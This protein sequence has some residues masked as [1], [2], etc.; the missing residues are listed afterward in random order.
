M[1]GKELAYVALIVKD[2]E[3]AAAAWEKDFGLVRSEHGVEGGKRK[4]PLMSVGQSA[5]ALFASG[6]PYVGG[7]ERT[8]VH[9]IALAVDHAASAA[10]AVGRAGVPTETSDT[11]A[12][13]DGGHRVLLSLKATDGLR[14]YLIDRFDR[15]VGKAGFVQR[16]DHLGVVGTDNPKAIDVYCKRLGCALLGEQFDTEIQ[17]SVE[18]FVYKTNETVRTIMYTRPAEFVAAVHDLFIAT[19]DCELE[20]IQ[21]L[22]TASTHKALGDQ[23]G[24]TKQDHGAIARFLSQRGPGLHHIAFK[25]EDIDARLQYLQKSDYRLID[26]KGRPGARCSRIGFLHPK[27]THGVLTHL[28]ERPDVV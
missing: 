13:L 16:I 18:H 24:N 20:I 19:G 2:V 28:V 11:E 1:Y 3:A 21:P 27:S 15:P 4:I 23:P 12:G 7:E 26:A 14:T 10:N 5:L 8:G 25:V 22:N 17:T 9:H 6:D